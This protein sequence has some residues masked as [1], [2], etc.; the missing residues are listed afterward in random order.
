MHKKVLSDKKTTPQLAWRYY[1]TE[2]TSHFVGYS[3]QKK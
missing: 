2:V 3:F 1:D